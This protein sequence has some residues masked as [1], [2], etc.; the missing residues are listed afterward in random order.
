MSLGL[1]HRRARLSMYLASKPDLIRKPG[2]WV[3]MVGSV[4]LPAPCL[5]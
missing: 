1:C 2:I 3:K 4:C 5:L